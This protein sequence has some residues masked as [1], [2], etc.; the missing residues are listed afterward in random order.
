MQIS[1][2]STD[3][4]SD[5]A[6]AINSANNNPGVSAAVITAADGQHLVLTSKQTGAANNVTVSAGAGLDSGLNTASFTQVAAGKDAT[7]SL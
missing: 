6:N 3:S 5:V 7:L 4:L 2:A 1:V